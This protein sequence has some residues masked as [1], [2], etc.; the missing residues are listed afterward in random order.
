MSRVSAARQARP[1]PAGPESA[2]PNVRAGPAHVIR[3]AEE[4][5]AARCDEAALVGQDDGL[6]AIANSELREE[7]R[8]VGLDRPFADGEPGGELG[9]ALATREPQ[10]HVALTLGQARQ[11]GADVPLCRAARELLDDPP[12]DRGRE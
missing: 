4:P 11:L 2:P 5:S 9:V 12:R 10:Q 7:A 1:S 8:D 3:T 6:H